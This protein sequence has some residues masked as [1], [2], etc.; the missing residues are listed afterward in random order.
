MGEAMASSNITLTIAPPASAGR[1][2]AGL[3]GIAAVTL[4]FALVP[5]WPRRPATDQDRH[6]I[7]V[8]SI[9][10][11]RNLLRLRG[12]SACHA[13]ACSASAA[14]WSALPRFMSTRPLYRPRARD[15]ELRRAAAGDDP[16]RRR[17]GADGRD[18]CAPAALFHHD[19]A[20]LNR[21]SITLRRPAAIWRRDGLQ[22]NTD[23]TLLAT[24][25][26]RGCR[27]TRLR[28]A[29]ALT[30]IGLRRLID[31]RFGVAAPGAERARLTA[32]GIPPLRHVAAFA[33]PSP[34]SAAR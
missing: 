6:R 17:L 2:Y 26:R 33:L 21:C 9:A 27:S 29:L 22:I 32:L 34:G 10:A 1:W 13:P 19:H 7:V 23:L 4:L 11:P 31:S 30:L 25:R 20:G 16:D 15:R 5:A 3:A 14:T 12:L 28:H 24:A 8:F 18:R